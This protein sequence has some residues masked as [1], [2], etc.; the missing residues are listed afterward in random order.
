MGLSCE[1]DWDA[2]P[3]WMRDRWVTARK[4]HVCCECLAEVEPGER[5]LDI[6]GVWV[7]GFHRF[8]T[9]ERCADLRE[10]Y[11]ALGYCTMFGTLWDDHLDMLE[12]D[13]KG[14]TRAG[15][16]ARAVLADR[17]RRRRERFPSIYGSGT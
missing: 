6:A 2:G 16:V 5:Y 7:S 3:T 12:M 8:P 9:C 17:E 10:S 13:G 14:E 11:E 1:C 15:A 4:R